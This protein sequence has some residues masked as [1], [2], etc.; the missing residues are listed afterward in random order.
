[1]Y[2]EQ[3]LMAS[4]PEAI[5]QVSAEDAS[6]LLDAVEAALA[7]LQE[8]RTAE[9]LQLKTSKSHTARLCQALTH[10]AGQEAKLRR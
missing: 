8:G 7:M 6:T 2:A 3:V 1:M 10:K 4:A 5:Q 9:L